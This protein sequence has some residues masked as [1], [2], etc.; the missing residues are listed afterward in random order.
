MPGNNG[1]ANFQGAA[2]DPGHGILFVVS[3][4]LP[5]MLKLELDTM[6]Q[7]PEGGSREDKGRAVYQSHCRSCHGADRAGQ[8]P[9]MPSL[10]DV[11]LRLTA[12]QVRAT[13]T[14]DAALCRL[15][16]MSDVTLDSLVTYLFH[17]E[18]THSGQALASR[19]KESGLASNAETASAPLSPEKLRYRSSFGFMFTR[20]GLPAIA[21]PWTTLTAYDLNRGTIQWQ[22]PLGEVPE[23]AARGFKDTG[24]HFPR[25][26]PWLLPAG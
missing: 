25:S 26:A 15:F 22:V 3:K 23:L 21:P 16:Q 1:G 24:S 20:S 9:A 6:E 5:S 11:G 18:R 14:G 12:D 10:A 13:V 19:P 8:P 4:D 7:V 17:P 2:V